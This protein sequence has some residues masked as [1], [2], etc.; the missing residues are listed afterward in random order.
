M[1][2]AIKWTLL[3]TALVLLIGMIVLLPFNQFINADEFTNA[4]NTIVSLCSNAFSFARGLINNFLSPF[5]RTVLTGLLVW[6]FGKKFL[7]VSIK[8]VSSVYHFI[9]K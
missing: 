4:I 6:L 5:G 9:F 1:S 8:I 2:D 7:M 3:G